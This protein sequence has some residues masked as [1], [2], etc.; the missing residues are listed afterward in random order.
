MIKLLLLSDNTEAVSACQKAFKQIDVCCEW[1]DNIENMNQRLVRG[2]Y[3]GLVLDVLATAKFSPKDK[4]F[5]QEVSEYYPTLMVRWN[6]AVQK[7]GGLVFGEI[8]DKEDPLG[9]FVKRFCRSDRALI[10]RENKRYD[11]HLNVLL[12]P[13]QKF[14]MERVEKTATLDLSRGG[15]FIISSHNWNN[16]D[17]AWIRLLELDDSSPIRVE[18]CS[19]VPWGK[20]TR[21]PGIGTKFIDLQP[22]Q[23]QEIYQYCDDSP[24]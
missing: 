1:V 22:N 14:S 9:D 19:Y 8:L 7:I 6:T 23:R 16:I 13:D 4:A 11:I 18:L 10:F 21:I 2:P 17:Y 20:Q 15:C 5:I 24:S 3:N 12:S